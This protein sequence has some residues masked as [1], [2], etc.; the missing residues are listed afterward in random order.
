MAWHSEGG[1]F[2]RLRHHG[3]VRSTGRVI[4]HTSKAA[5]R[6]LLL[7]MAILVVVACLLAGAAWRL[8]QGPIDLRW[9]S[10]RVKAAL[11]DDGAP[12]RVSFDGVFLV[13]EGF[14][15]GVDHPLDVSL[16]NIVVTDQGGRQLVAAPGAHLTFSLAGLMLG[17]I[18][19][20][21]IEVDHAQIAVTRDAVGAIDLGQALAAGD[22]SGGDLRQLREQLSRPASSDYGRS[23]G[24]LDQIQRAHFRDTEVMLRDQASGLVVGTSDM[25]F[26]LTRTRAGHVRGL[27]RA[28][29]RVGGEQA[30]LT[31]N[32]DWTVGSGVD[33]E[34]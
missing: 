18:V 10:D 14:H 29:L 16:S 12:V 19:P 17:R 24:L 34:H 27:L 6:L 4:H 33:A 5:H 21:A 8:A 23:R 3:A 9:L 11:V 31:A 32:A 22:S 20:R 25:D 2:H 7:G 26:D 1:W 28:G 15:K 30:G 13:W